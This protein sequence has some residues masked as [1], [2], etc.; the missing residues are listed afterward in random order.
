MEPSG[1][2]RLLFGA[3]AVAVVAL[4]LCAVIFAWPD[5]F[6]LGP[7]I[8]DR[9]KPVN[10]PMP[11]AAN[12]VPGNVPKPN[13]KDVVPKPVE[14]K[15]AE[16]VK[17]ANGL[18]VAKDGTGQYTSIQAAINDAKAGQTIRV[19][20]DAVYREH[21]QIHRA[22]LMAG[23]TLEAVNGATISFPEGK[24]G[25]SLSE[26]P[27]VTLRGFRLV[28]EGNLLYMIGVGGNCPGLH[29]DRLEFKSTGTVA[30][31]VTMESIPPGG[32]VCVV[33]HC[34]IT[35]PFLAGLRV[36]GFTTYASPS[37]TGTIVLRDNTVVGAHHGILVVGCI[38]DV[39]VVGN[40]VA[41]AGRS[42]IQI[43]N[44]LP[45]AGNIVI[46]NNTVLDSSISVRIWDDAKKV[47]PSG[48]SIINNLVLGGK[49]TDMLFI[50]SGGDPSAVR[51]AGTGQTLIDRWHWSHNV[52]EAQEP[53]SDDVLARSWIPVAGADKLE[54]KVDLDRRD[55]KLSDFLRPT[56]GSPLGT[57][58]KGGDF[59]AYVGALPPEGVEPWNWQWTWDAQMR[60]L[61][62]VSKNK[63]DAARFRTLNDA[64]KAAGKGMTIRVL[65]DAEYPE[66]L[67]ISRATLHEGLMLESPRKAIIA[68]KK[69]TIAIGIFN[70]PRV[71]VRGFRLRA[72]SEGISLI[73]VM[74]RS[75]SAVLEDLE[76]SR[77]ESVSWYR[78]VSI[79]HVDATP[80][81]APIIVQNCTLH[82]TI[83]GIRVS[84]LGDE[85][86]SSIPIRR[87]IIRDNRLIE[88]SV[89][90]IV[91]GTAKDVMIVGNRVV[92]ATV[93][94]IQ[95]E[96]ILRGTENILIANNTLVECTAA[97][98]FRDAPAITDRAVN[99]QI[100]NNLVLDSRR[101]DM[102][103]VDSGG[104]KDKD[105]GPGDGSSISGKW[106]LSN[107]WREITVPTAGFSKDWIPPSAKDAAISERLD[108][109]AREAGHP[110]FL[111][112][113]KGSA[114]AKAGGD[115]HLPGHV[116][117][118][119][120]EGANAWNWDWTWDAFVNNRVTVSKKAQ[121]GG[122]FR[123]ISDALDKVDGGM[124]IRVLDDAVYQK[125]PVI[126]DRFRHANLVVES[127]KRA[128]VVMPDAASLGWSIM[129]PG[130]KVHGFRLRGIKPGSYT[131]AVSGNSAGAV[132]ENLEFTT[133][134]QFTTAITVEQL[135]LRPDEDP[136]TVR[137]CS[138]QGYGKGVQVFGMIV[139][140]RSSNPCNR[141][142]VYGNRF[143]NVDKAI[144]CA[145]TVRDI[146]LA[147]NV[148]VNCQA[149]LMVAD[150]LADSER[151][152]FVNN[153][154]L[155][156]RFTL[157]IADQKTPIKK[158][159]I[160]NNLVL[161]ERGADFVNLTKDPKLIASW[162]I[163]NNWRE[164]KPLQPADDEYPSW[165][166]SPDDKIVQDIP[167]VA[168][169]PTHKDFLRPKADSPL[170]TGGIGNGLPRYVG[171]FAPPGT[172]AWDWTTFWKA[173]KK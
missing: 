77:A 18:T 56:K 19:L 154:S 41:Y 74:G 169:D 44:L 152:H 12:N 137:N 29:L 6:G 69:G 102:I 100:R 171:A 65:D 131:I 72:E 97:L 42:G 106:I 145:G 16:V 21:L 92:G 159:H 58:G 158:V 140:N 118:V 123:S 43:E 93:G 27:S 155:S 172:T 153:S 52:R 139:S 61:I 87:V 151:I 133:Q 170:A 86:Q 68:P 47:M 79:E 109:L 125:T 63:D 135:A 78:G 95:M 39:Y 57:A 80:N 50:D 33:E 49:R 85:Y 163:R 157:Q 146:L 124:T 105:I 59:P 167:L 66:S 51:G 45:G 25:I 142:A 34:K 143:D 128:T 75:P 90:I 38:K 14:P 166:Q 103:Y 71:S 107:N 113:K 144:M 96:R 20:D 82:R 28:N 115:S 40:R 62:T 88:P 99:V 104:D 150:V 122:R 22:A 31:A 53:N 117:A 89:G 2:R 141:I 127:P 35:G 23:I 17:I 112:P 121:D 162:L 9:E 13:G 67:L 161:T 119:A 110:D 54:D 165:I 64:L 98:R 116:G 148:F 84:G 136:V 5:L 94:A 126:R 164:I 30:G 129:A 114:L 147:G 26:T 156:P 132:L 101:P 168:R 108:I 15:K 10:N 130:V 83:S 160:Q 46:A 149:S 7:S 60:K 32:D 73:A 111:R 173:T 134:A 70:V 91:M 138:F 4:G 81:D 3:S 76:M 1:D 24:L 55:P 11:N 37:P 48:V 120:P 36:S 8:R